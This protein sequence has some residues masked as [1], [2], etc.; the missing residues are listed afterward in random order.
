VASRS[1]KVESGSFADDIGLLE[2]DI[3]VGINRTPIASVEDIRNVQS[4]LKLVTPWP[5]A[6]CA[7]YPVGPA[8]RGLHARPPCS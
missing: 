6:W 1:A 7:G 4:K 8:R 2:K 5:S 3:I